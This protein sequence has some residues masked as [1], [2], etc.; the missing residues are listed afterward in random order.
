M[1]PI[2]APVDLPSNMPESSSTISDSFRCV[3]I[4]DCPGRRRSNSPCIAA[5][6]IET[7]A[8]HPS[9]TPPMAAPCDSPKVVS[10]NVFPRVFPAMLIFCSEF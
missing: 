3:V 7:P 8:G 9:I 10:L 6:S 2:G 5:I 1:N 4:F